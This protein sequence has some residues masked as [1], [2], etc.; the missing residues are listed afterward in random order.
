M[1]S[2]GKVQCVSRDSAPGNERGS[3]TQG[4]G[5]QLTGEGRHRTK[6]CPLH[7]PTPSVRYVL[8]HRLK[9]HEGLSDMDSTASLLMLY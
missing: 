8:R 6:A 1:T 2:H 7:S 4:R 3:V 5:R 9:A